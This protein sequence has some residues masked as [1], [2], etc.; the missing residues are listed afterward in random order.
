[1][2]Q[3]YVIRIYL[4]GNIEKYDEVLHTLGLIL[5]MKLSSGYSLE[6]IDVIKNPDAAIEGNV[7]VTPTVQ[8]VVPSPGTRAVGRLA[9]KSGI[10]ALVEAMF[11]LPPKENKS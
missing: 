6:V 8:V 1:M 7:F 10:T 4:A 5:R 9:D 3:K 11:T 2:T